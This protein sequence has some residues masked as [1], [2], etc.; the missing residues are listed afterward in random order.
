MFTKKTRKTIQNHLLQHQNQ[1]EIVL[2]LHHQTQVEIALK[3]KETRK[4]MIFPILIMRK[5][6]ANLLNKAK[7]L[8]LKRLKAGFPMFRGNTLWDAY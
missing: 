4:I 5:R 1:L 7:K 8:P 2:N 3:L 6:Q